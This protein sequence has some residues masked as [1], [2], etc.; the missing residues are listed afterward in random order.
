MSRSVVCISRT[1]GALGEDL[2]RIV[3][4]KLGFRY[5]DDEIVV[6]AAELAGVPAEVIAE[7]ERSDAAAQYAPLV[8]Q[9][10]RETADQG[11]VVIVAHGASIPLAGRPDVLRVLVTASAAT[12]A[13]WLADKDD[14]ESE[15]AHEAIQES[16]RE[17]ARFLERFY[18]VKEELPTHYDVIINT[19]TLTIGRAARVVMQAAL[20]L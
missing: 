3:A 12:R 18:D 17:R 6:R 4:E 19:E 8:E 1:T 9:V 7:S 10:I 2:A 13:G 16:D 14:V 11:D 20:T 15:A 5:V